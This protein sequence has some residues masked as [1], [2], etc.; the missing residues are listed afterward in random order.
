MRSRFLGAA[1]RRHTCNTN[2][3]NRKKMIL[4]A[5]LIVLTSSVCGMFAGKMAATFYQAEEDNNITIRWD[6][7]TK[8]DMSLAN[9]ACFLLSEP[10]KLLYEMINGVE[11]PESQHQQFAGRVQC[12]ED[13]LRDGRIRLH[14]SRLRT[15]DSGNYWCDLAAH[16]NKVTRRWALETTEH[17]VLNVTS[18][19]ENSDV[20]TPALT[21]DAEHTPGGPEKKVTSHDWDE[22]KTA[23]GVINC[24]FVIV[25]GLI[26]LL[27]AFIDVIKSLRS[28][29]GD[30]P[31]LSSC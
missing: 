27:L 17:F 5:L 31:S 25:A 30:V 3:Q 2:T 29:P 22:V 24:G 18:H 12:D 19:G 15:E 1:D 8:T 21:E 20:F 23:L 7:R 9:M 6:S 10:L 4:A 26:I 16:Y 14:V 11:I 13:A 28:T